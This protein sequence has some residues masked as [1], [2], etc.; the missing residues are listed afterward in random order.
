MIGLPLVVAAIVVGLC[1]AVRRLHDLGKTGW[2]V[3]GIGLLTVVIQAPAAVA[4]EAGVIF[5]LL[6]ALIS[7]G[8]TLW[9]GLA[10]GQAGENRFGPPPGQPLAPTAEDQLE[11]EEIHYSG[12]D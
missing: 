3:L 4:G 1:N 9:L 7:L 11:G 10:K 6:A 12:E 2:W 5:S 8:W